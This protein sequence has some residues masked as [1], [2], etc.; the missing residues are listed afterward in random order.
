MTAAPA[1][2]AARVAA[3]V[4]PAVF[5]A[6]DGLVTVLGILF[7]LS[8]APTTL[9]RSGIGLAAAGAVSM[10]GGE[11]LSAAADSPD[12]FWEAAAIGATTGAGTLIPVVPYMVGGGGVAAA[13]SAVLCLATAGLAAWLKTTE[14]QEL[15]LA[16]SAAQTYGLLLAAGAVTLLC[17]WATG[18]V[19]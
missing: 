18:A 5:G 4:R 17:A 3:L 14:N 1:A 8:A 7:A 9:V 12:K 19:G 16:R 10:A 11:W 15:S 6:F 13:V 2:R